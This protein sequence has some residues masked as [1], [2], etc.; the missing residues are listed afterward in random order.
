MTSL[1]SKVVNDIDAEEW[2]EYDLPKLTLREI[3][4]LCM[5]LCS[6]KSG[7]KEKV[8]TRLLAV[9]QVRIKLAPFA[10]SREGMEAVVLSFRKEALQWMAKEA[11]LWRSGNKLQLANVLINWR[12]RCRAEGQKFL[13]EALAQI[14]N[15]PRQMYLE[16]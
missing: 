10:A 15:Q 11:G 3:Q 12:E 1:F 4:C 8:V 5:L 6:P 7:T 16:L 2:N 13:Q 9:R 14:L